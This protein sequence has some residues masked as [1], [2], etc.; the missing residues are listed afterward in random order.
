MKWLMLRKSTMYHE[1]D[2]TIADLGI[3]SSLHWTQHVQIIMS[4]M[5]FGAYFGYCFL[6][7]N[8]FKSITSP[9][10]LNIIMIQ[11]CWT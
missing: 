8:T 6:E 1:K 9:M 4:P 11:Y 7:N 5:F 2:L 3:F 10:L